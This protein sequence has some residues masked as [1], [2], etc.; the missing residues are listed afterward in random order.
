MDL[1][2]IQVHGLRNEK[3][4]STPFRL[5]AYRYIVLIDIIASLKIS[6][7]IVDFFFE[8]SDRFQLIFAG[9]PIGDQH[10]KVD[11]DEA[12]APG[13][14]NGMYY[15]LPKF[16]SVEIESYL[17]MFKVLLEDFLRR[18]TPAIVEI[19]WLVIGHRGC[20]R[21]HAWPGKLSFRIL[22]FRQR[23]QID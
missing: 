19:G 2:Q 17:Y 10:A 1:A 7:P 12:I 5:L 13:E 21:Q 18:R 4:S 9:G 23:L 6:S 8:G 14:C 15:I 3:V 11:A 22:F 16:L 20:E